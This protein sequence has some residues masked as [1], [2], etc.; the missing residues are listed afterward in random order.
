MKIA[1]T[2]HN[3]DNDINDCIQEI[4]V[5]N[6]TFTSH[7]SSWNVEKVGPITLHVTSYNPLEGRSY[8]ETPDFIK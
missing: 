6:E 8:I 3:L 5:N 1:L 7:S 2:Q 4:N